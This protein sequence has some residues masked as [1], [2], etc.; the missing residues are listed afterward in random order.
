MQYPIDIFVQ[1]KEAYNKGNKHEASKK[2]M[3]AIGGEKTSY[4]ITSSIDK[5]MNPDTII[6]G[7]IIQLVNHETTTRVKNG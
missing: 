2:V 3:E 1:A 6:H 7:L 4:Q 5:I